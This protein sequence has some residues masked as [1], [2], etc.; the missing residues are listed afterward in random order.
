MDVNKDG[1]EKFVWNVISSGWWKG[2]K[3]R[4]FYAFYGYE[5]KANNL[6]KL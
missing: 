3:S 4:F 1:L 6:E 5:N 2:L